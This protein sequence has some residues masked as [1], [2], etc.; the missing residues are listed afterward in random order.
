V[1]ANQWVCAAALLLVAG[2]RSKPIFEPEDPVKVAQAAHCEKFAPKREQC[3]YAGDVFMA[4]TLVEKPTNDKR[5]KRNPRVISGI[6]EFQVMKDDPD[7]KPDIRPCPDVHMTVSNVAIL[8]EN[9]G[10]TVRVGHAKEAI[11]GGLPVGSY[12][13]TSASE[14]Y[15]INAQIQDIPSGSQVKVLL[16]MPVVIVPAVP[17]PTKSSHD[18]KAPRYTSTCGAASADLGYGSASAPNISLH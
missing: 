4:V 17:P 3:A 18:P 13:V 2:C 16:Q 11:V 1:P 8:G 15:K 6:C 7:A 12:N 5:D 10:R 9:G 14:L